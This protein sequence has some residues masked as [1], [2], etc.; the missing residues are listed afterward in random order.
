MQV[1]IHILYNSS[2]SPAD[3]TL[4]CIY[5]IL[6]SIAAQASSCNTFRSTYGNYLKNHV[7]QTSSGSSLQKCTTS[8]LETYFCKSTNYN[9]VNNTC[10]LNNAD[11]FEYARDLVQREGFSYSGWRYLPVSNTGRITYS[12]L[13]AS[14]C[15]LKYGCCTL[16]KSL[17]CLAAC[18][19]TAAILTQVC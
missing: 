14:N 4:V 12:C 2:G 9:F 19:V 8:C 7:V 3:L 5:V 18:D 1:F 15:K 6:R 10:E 13:Q 16:F 11:K 17:H